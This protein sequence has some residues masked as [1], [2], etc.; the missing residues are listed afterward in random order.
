MQIHI[1]GDAPAERAAWDA[2]VARCP[3][4][5]VLQCSA[6]GEF[7]R[8]AGWQPL[9]LAVAGADG[10]ALAGAQVLLRRLPLRSGVIAYS[11]RGPVGRWRDPVLAAALWPALHQALR[12]RRAIFLKIEPN[13]APE[14]TLDTALAALHFLKLSSHIQP[15]ATFQVD[16]GRELAALSSSFKPKTR[17]N[18][19]LAGRKGVTIS[20]GG[21]DDLGAV[22]PL[23]RATSERDGFP[24]HTLDYYQALL[25][26]M[27]G[28]AR[29]TLARHEGN[30]LAAIFVAAFGRESIY[31]HGASSNE[32]RN[33]MPTYLIQWEA[34]QW[35]RGR[36]CRYY[37]LWGIP[38]GASEEAGGEDAVT[39][40]VEESG[41]PAG[42]WGVYRFK[43]GFG[44]QLARYAGAYDYVYSPLL[45]RTWQELLPR[46]RA[47]LFRRIGM[48]QDE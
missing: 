2:F 22:Y 9:R 13:A 8:Q 32:K 42:L 36:G 33:L 16:L 46:Y 6:W 41:R 26:D 7:K 15:T 21:L 43:S 17:Y 11:A 3:D 14:P 45:Y 40:H 31:L 18:I 47:L 38:E 34:M 44:G 29:L 37:D 35:A 24:I 28:V 10:T 4:G 25:R 19:G 1:Y 39:Q 30:L 23:L 5:G 20:E 48:R 12:R 27:P